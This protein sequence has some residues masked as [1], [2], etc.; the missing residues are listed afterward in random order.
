MKKVAMTVAMLCLGLASSN[1]MNIEKVD[2]ESWDRETF[3][4]YAMRQ[5]VNGMAKECIRLL[6]FLNNAFC[7][8]NNISKKAIEKSVIITS[9]EYVEN[10]LGGHHVL[11]KKERE[12]LDKYDVLNCIL[13]NVKNNGGSLGDL[14]SLYLSIISAGKG[15]LG[16]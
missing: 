6:D 16:G 1:A 15:L 12:F 7:V 5:G 10:L 4:A 11:S 9:R 13:E 2:S 8:K 3:D 14:K